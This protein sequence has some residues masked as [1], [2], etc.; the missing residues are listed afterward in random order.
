MTMISGGLDTT[1]ACILLGIAYLSSP[2]GQE[3]QKHAY[4]EINK[5][6]PDGDAWEKCV[7]EE[8]V[9]YM[10]A[11]IKEILR[12]WTV[13][14]MAL[15]RVSIKDI[16]WQDATIPAGTTFIMVRADPPFN[17]TNVPSLSTGSRQIYKMLRLETECLGRRL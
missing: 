14:P 3:I 9:E 6:Y 2:H 15:P 13:V 5:A 10:S 12:F 8:K 1:P 16:K 11:L 4:E 17:G 7:S